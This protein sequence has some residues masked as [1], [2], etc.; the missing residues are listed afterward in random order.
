MYLLASEMVFPVTANLWFCFN[1]VLKL[2]LV[3]LILILFRH[4]NQQ[5]MSSSFFQRMFLC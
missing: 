5:H 1:E 3:F 2:V 4:L